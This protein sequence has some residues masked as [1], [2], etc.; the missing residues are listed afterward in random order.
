MTVHSE[1]IEFPGTQ[2][3]LAARLDRPDGP[4]RAHAL[5]AHCFTC[6]K[7]ILAAGRIA[8]RLTGDGIAVLRF[9]F[10]GLG[11][12]DGEFANTNFTSNVDDLLAAA[13]WLAETHGAPALLIGHSLGGAAVLKAARKVDGCKAVATI[14]AP[15]DP[16]H[17]SH[18]FGES[19]SIIE[20]EGEA[21]VHLAGR[22]FRITRQFLDDIRS[23]SIEDDVANLRRALL[24][25]HAPFDRTVGIDNAARIFAAAKHPKSFLSLDHADHLL[26][27]PEDAEYVAAVIAVWA[28]RYLNGQTSTDVT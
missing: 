21:E 1:R 16:A 11:A 23:A 26:S 9:D 24:V 5:F 3:K 7:D 14:G 18:N 15:F 27:Q 8:K 20:R 12:S 13:R 17:V 25:A 6:T 22:P 10:T 2:G 28:A 4:I 19:I